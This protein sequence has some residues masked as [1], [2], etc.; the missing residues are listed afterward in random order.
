MK[1][2]FKLSFISTF[3]CLMVLKSHVTL[4]QDGNLIQDAI[5]YVSKTSDFGIDQSCSILDTI[6]LNL[7]FDFPTTSVD[8]NEIWPLRK[9]MRYGKCP[10]YNIF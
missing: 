4:A 8:L 3:L 10:Q 6:N 2:H 9:W 1:V 5:D 7:Q